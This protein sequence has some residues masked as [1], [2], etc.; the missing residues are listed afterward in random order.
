MDRFVV[1]KRKCNPA[2][3]GPTE[4]N[5]ITDTSYANADSCKERYIDKQAIVASNISALWTTESTDTIGVGGACSSTLSSCGNVE[6]YAT[7]KQHMR[8]FQPLGYEK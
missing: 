3:S 1:R 2:S 8:S 5:S 4:T 6:K 7:L